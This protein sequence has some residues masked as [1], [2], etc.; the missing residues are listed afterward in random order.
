MKSLGITNQSV[1][2]T[3]G[4]VTKAADLIASVGQEPTLDVALDRDKSRVTPEALKDNV[5]ALRMERAFIRFGKKKQKE[6]NDDG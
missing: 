2:S 3:C 1:R 4:P 6:N 5:L